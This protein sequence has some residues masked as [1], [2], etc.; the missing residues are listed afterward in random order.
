MLKVGDRVVFTNDNGVAFGTEPDKPL[1]ISKVEE[2]GG[3]LLYSHEPTDT[4][5]YN[6]HKASYF[7]LYDEYVKPPKEKLTLKSGDEAEYCY[8][9]FWGN[10][11]Y[12]VKRLKQKITV[13]DGVVHTITQEDEPAF[14]VKPEFQLI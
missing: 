2:V 8:T 7:T 13:V 6:Q 4:P 11:V 5:W 9:T 12:R 14:P 10:K 1:H 3:E